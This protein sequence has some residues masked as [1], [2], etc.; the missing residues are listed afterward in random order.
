VAPGTAAWPATE[1][2][3]FN[4]ALFTIFAVHHSVLA[5]PGVKRWL[6]R[7]APAEMERTA[8]VWCASVLFIGMCLAWRPAAG[9]VW[10]LRG[11]MEVLGYG[12]QLAGLWFTVTGA[13]AVDVLDLA[14][15]RWVLGGPAAVDAAADLT[16]R[17]PYTFV[18]HP[19]YLGWVLLTFG[20]P[21]MTLGRLTFAFISFVYL[22]VAIPL[23]ERAL[24][25]RHG[26]SYRRY[27][28]RVRWRLLP[29]MY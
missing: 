20:A 27:Q 15:V 11:G 2:V 10:E 3:T 28:S 8:F 14:G 4:F 9:V 13:R 25:A 12:M 5:R 16:E 19:I 18:R 24:V 29:G 1:A 23:E 26:E 6:H 17:G 7:L 21:Q 22:L